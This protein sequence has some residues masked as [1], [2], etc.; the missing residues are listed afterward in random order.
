LPRIYQKSADFLISAVKD[1]METMVF[2]DMSPSEPTQPEG[3]S[4]AGDVVS[5]LGFTGTENGIFVTSVG[6]DLARKI[7]ANMLGMEEEEIQD[8]SEISDAMGEL[9]NM[10]AGN[11]KVLWSDEGWEMEISVPVVMAGKELEA[12]FSRNL[13]EGAAVDFVNEDGERLRVEIRLGE[14]PIENG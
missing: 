1:V 4:L 8:K 6:M 12:R 11:V 9:T 10:I 2:M 13:V 3:T 14:N 5:T 7:T